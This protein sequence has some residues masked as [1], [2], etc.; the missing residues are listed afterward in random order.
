MGRKFTIPYG[1]YKCHGF[2]SPNLASQ[3]QFSEQ[4]LDLLWDSLL[5]MFEHD[6]S[7]SRGLMQTRGLYVFK[8]D[9][10]LGNA[11]A[12][13]LFDTIRI[14]KQT[15]D[16]VARSFNDYLVEA[17][18]NLVPQGVKLIQM[19]LERVGAGA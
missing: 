15:P 17:D 19:H 8:H 4:D 18:T 6:R 1:L 10:E 11:P 7:A 12:H 16:T 13:K 3:T 14:K 9:S 2:F 5:N